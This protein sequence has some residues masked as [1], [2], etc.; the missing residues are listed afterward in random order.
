VGLG[1]GA[2]GALAEAVAQVWALEE[3][4]EVGLV[5]GGRGGAEEAALEGWG[6]GGEDGALA[7]G[8][9]AEEG[10]GEGAGLE[11]GGDGD[12]G[13]GVEVEVG[14]LEE[15]VGVGAQAE[16]LDAAVGGEVGGVPVAGVVGADGEEGPLRGVNWWGR[17]MERRRVVLGSR[18]RVALASWRERVRWVGWRAMG[19]RALRIGSRPRRWRASWA[20][21]RRR[22]ATTSATAIPTQKAWSAW[23]A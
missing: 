19:R 17:A 8:A 11:E 14:G 21:E 4:G 18:P 22:A 7:V 1:D 6:V 23:S 12:D 10:R 13:E 20:P 5:L 2:L 3:A 15:G 16:G 9:E